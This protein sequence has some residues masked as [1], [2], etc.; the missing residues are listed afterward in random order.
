M[1]RNITYFFFTK[2]DSDPSRG[3]LSTFLGWM[4]ELIVSNDFNKRKK[5]IICEK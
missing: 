4:G 3:I 1:T 5:K 2:T